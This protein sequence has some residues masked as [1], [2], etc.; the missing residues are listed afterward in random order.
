[1]H[2]HTHNQRL[3]LGSVCIDTLHRPHE[4]AKVDR[5][6]QLIRGLGRRRF[7]RWRSPHNTSWDIARFIT[8]MDTNSS[9]PSHPYRSGISG[10][11]GPQFHN[12]RN[13]WRKP[14]GCWCVGCCCFLPEQL[15]FNV[16]L[17]LEYDNISIDRSRPSLST[18]FSI[19]GQRQ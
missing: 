5:I 7:R 11:W 1:V 19:H 10:K 13:F 16:K 9:K 18:E 4:T 6:A 14:M 17:D 3:N 15:Q 8:S 2:D 12:L